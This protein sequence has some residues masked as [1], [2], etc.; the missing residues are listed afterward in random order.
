V[1]WVIVIGEA[2]SLYMDIASPAEK[3]AF[4]IVMLAVTAIHL[5]TSPATA[6]PDVVETGIL[7]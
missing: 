2:L 6:V 5:P 1:P 3:V 7:R 4:G